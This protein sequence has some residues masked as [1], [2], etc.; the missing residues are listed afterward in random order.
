MPETQEKQE[1]PENQYLTAQEVAR[2][3]GVSPRTVGNWIRDG[4][5]PAHRTVGGHAR[6]SAAAL[7]SFLAQRGIPAGGAELSGLAG[8]VASLGGGPAKRGEGERQRVARSRRRVLVIDDDEAL[9]EVV[10]ELLGALGYEV[11]TARHGFLGGYLLAH[12]RPEA[13]LLDIMMPGLDGFEVL[14]LLR[15][16]P[17][18]RAIPVLACTSLRG[19]EVEARAGAAGFAGLVHKPIDFT[20]L[21][22]RLDALLA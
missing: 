19:P 16:R 17:E 8:G 21:R 22:K 13:I 10:R 4:L 1:I 5:I 15:E 12:Y 18:G 7:R 14:R 6:V 2:W 3:C 20:E 11:E 9:L